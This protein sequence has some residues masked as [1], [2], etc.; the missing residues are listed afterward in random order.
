MRVVFPGFGHSSNLIYVYILGICV[1]SYKHP[2]HLNPL[3][4]LALIQDHEDSPIPQGSLTNSGGG[5]NLSG[6]VFMTGNSRG[7][8]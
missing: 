4:S 3:L 6:S 2:S 7:N 8:P 1:G 5:I